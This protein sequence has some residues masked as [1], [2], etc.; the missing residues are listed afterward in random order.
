LAR[1]ILTLVFVWLTTTFAADTNAPPHARW[2]ADIK[3]FEAADQTNPPPK[4]AVVFVGSSS[5][6]L[7]KTAPAQFPNHRI[8][9]RGFGGSHL[10]DSVAFAERIVIPYRPKLVV[11]YAGDNDIASGKTPERVREDF[12]AFVAKI[13]G[14]LPETRIAYLAIKPS[15]SRLKFFDQHKATNELIREVIAA[16]HRL[17]YVDTWTPILGADGKPRDEFFLK[18]RLH[19]NAAGYKQWAG[20]VG[21]VLDKLGLPL[22]Q[23]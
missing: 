11:L 15:S 19:L 7:W 8:L 9:N 17:I 4:G 6:R 3:A 20:I 2:E 1:G 13:H 12:Q 16:D 22:K 10:S 14:P 5:I 18:D 21:P 23:N